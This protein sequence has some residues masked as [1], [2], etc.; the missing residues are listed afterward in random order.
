MP[1]DQSFGQPGLTRWWP[2]A[3]NTRPLS[4][5]E[6]G[7]T[8]FSAAHLGM[9]AWA[10]P[11]FY[12]DY[13]GESLN[14][15]A[16][17]ASPPPA[18]TSASRI[19]GTEFYRWS[20][21]SAQNASPGAANDAGEPFPYSGQPLPTSFA[22]SAPPANDPPPVTSSSLFGG[23][24][25]G[26]KAPPPRSVLFRQ[27]PAIFDLGGHDFDLD[28]SP[29]SLGLS[30]LPISKSGEPY[31]PA[32]PPLS[33]SP[34]QVLAASRVLA[35]NLVDYFTKSVPPPPA[36]PSTP[37][38]IQSWDY[39]PY[40]PGAINDAANLALLAA[41][42]FAGGEATPLVAARMAD[43]AAPAAATSALRI[44][45][46]RSLRGQLLA[47]W[48]ANHLNQNSVYQEII[49]RLDGLSVAMKG[50]I[51]TE[52]GTPHYKFHQS[53]E[54]FWDQYRAGGSLESGMPTNA[55]YGQ[56]MRRA[57]TAAG[58]SPAEASGLSAR[59]AAERAAFGLRET[60]SVP[61]IPN[62]IWRRRR[63]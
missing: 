3:Y 1:F 27:S 28:Q 54:Q 53:L 57:L 59:A 34:D 18:P 32:P 56:A 41:S 30:D 25:D 7:G 5:V 12:K 26:S 44:G 29:L 61:R 39:N 21:D 63:D 46:Y 48:Q 17:T 15:D 49:D 50:N 19:P 37:G 43:E 58:L 14:S 36:F 40:V 47:G 20:G 13:P 9:F 35:P 16:S 10:P 2:G 22:Q 31:F 55:E 33:H 11:V 62:A 42:I 4:A 45:S 24:P 51:L 60:D 52:P 6:L 23:S 38:K 8:P